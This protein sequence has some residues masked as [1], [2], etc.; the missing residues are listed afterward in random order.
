LNEAVERLNPLTRARDDNAAVALSWL[1]VAELARSRPEAALRAAAAARALNPNDPL[2]TYT[3]ALTLSELHDPRAA[4][5][6]E[7]A[8]HL[9]PGQRSLERAWAA[10]N[11]HSSPPLISRQIAASNGRRKAP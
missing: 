6:L 3:V 7:R 10:A 5:W 8:R 11:P 4:A 2:V 9:V 1:A